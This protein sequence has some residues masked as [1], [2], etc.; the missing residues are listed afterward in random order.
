MDVEGRV[1]I[2]IWMTS[3]QDTS[4]TGGFS[5]VDETRWL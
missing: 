2:I 3:A 5:A 4:P 1:T